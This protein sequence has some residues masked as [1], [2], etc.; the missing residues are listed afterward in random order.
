MAQGSE[1]GI[2]KIKRNKTHGQLCKRLAGS[3]TN[4]SSSPIDADPLNYRC[5][6]GKMTEKPK[7]NEK[8]MS[9]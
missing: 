5:D 1:N 4:Y 8:L 9:P 3:W 2:T 6:S 7:I